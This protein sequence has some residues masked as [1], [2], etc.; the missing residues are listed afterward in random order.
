MKRKMA[1]DG[2]GD[3]DRNEIR[4]GLKVEFYP[5][6]MT[7]TGGLCQELFYHLSSRNHIAL[8]LPDTAQTHLIYDLQSI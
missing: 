1:K 5:S 8:A 7:G 3:M 6:S 2:A 4:Q